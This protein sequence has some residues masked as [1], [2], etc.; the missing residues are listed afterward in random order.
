MMGPPPFG[1][2]PAANPNGA[3]ALNPGEYEETVNSLVRDLMLFMESPY[4]Y[5]HG[6]FVQTP[7]LRDAQWRCRPQLVEE[8]RGCERAL[9]DNPAADITRKLYFITNELKSEGVNTSIWEQS[10]CR[11]AP[12]LMDSA[13]LNA[14]GMG[15]GSGSGGHGARGTAKGGGSGSGSMIEICPMFNSADGCR[16]GDNCKYQHVTNRE[17]ELKQ[18]LSERVCGRYD[19]DEV[20]FATTTGAGTEG[21]VRR[22]TFYSFFGVER[23]LK[24]KTARSLHLLYSKKLRQCP[25]CSL[26]VT[27]DQ[28]QKHMTWHFG[29]RKLILQRKQV[30]DSLKTQ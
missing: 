11:I 28:F 1:G 2:A 27:V 9:R 7:R 20:K 13:N 17:A 26:R 8:V 23:D 10:L 15:N 4:S 12:F 5:Q 18:K 29:R 25:N 21:E 16:S 30:L 22:A 14:N 19:L 24:K 3:N 6:L